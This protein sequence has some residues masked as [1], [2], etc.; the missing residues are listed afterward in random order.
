MA[1][2]SFHEDLDT[3]I[4]YPIPTFSADH[5]L[6][7]SLRFQSYHLVS[8]FFP[9]LRFKTKYLRF[10][11]NLRTWRRNVF[12]ILILYV[13]RSG[14][15]CVDYSVGRGNVLKRTLISPALT[16]AIRNFLT[17]S[18]YLF[19]IIFMKQ[20]IWYMYLMQNADNHFSNLLVSWLSCFAHSIS[21][22]PPP[23]QE[24]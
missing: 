14:L 6:G 2:V 4:R 12:L 9:R 11:T 23:P 19:L 7:K 1:W 3:W 5:A 22:I 10:C 16:F 8:D 15:R 21:C 24:G 13:P 17:L 18:I 20:I